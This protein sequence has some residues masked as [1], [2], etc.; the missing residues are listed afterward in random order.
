MAEWVAVTTVCALIAGF[1]AFFGW[2][3]RIDQAL[4]DV[5]M[6]SLKQ[7][8]DPEVVIVAIDEKSLARLGRWPWSRRVHAEL[9]DR[10]REAG[11]GP[12][13]LDILFS[14]RQEEASGDQV[15][16]EAIRRHG[17]V[18]LPWAGNTSIGAAY[19]LGREPLFARDA[20]A[21]GHAHVEFDP[22]GIVRSVYLWE[23]NGEVM[24]PQ[25]GLA[26]LI[27][28][29]PPAAARYV[30]DG[31]RPAGA[32]PASHWLRIPFSGPPGAHRRVSFVD[33]LDR[34]ADPALLKGKV[35]LVGAVAQGMG[36]VVPTPTSAYTRPMPGVEVNA[37]IFSALRGDRTI[38]VASPLGAA[39]LSSLAV[40]VLML[41]MVRLSPRES[42]L[43]AFAITGA[44][45]LAP[46]VALTNWHVWLPPA[47]ALIG[48]MAAYPL[49]SWRRLE[50]TQRYL[51]EELDALMREAG[52]WRPV[53]GEGDS[54]GERSAD[55]VYRRLARLRETASRQRQLRHF[56]LDTLEGL[57]TGVVV[58]GAGSQLQLH[59][60]RAGILLGAEG[61]DE[62]LPVLR[63][64]KWP[65][66]IPLEDGLPV[67]REEPISVEVLGAEGQTL[68]VT[69]AALHDRRSRMHGVVLSM[70]DITQIKQAQARR[71]AAMQYLSHDLRSPLSSIVTM[72]EAFED[73]PQMAHGVPRDAMQRVSLYAS[74]ALELTENLFRL[75][76]AEGVDVRRFVMYDLIQIADDAI[77]EAWAL[78]RA[79]GVHISR[80]ELPDDE[81]PVLCEPSLLK[82]AVLNLLTNAVKYSPEGSEVRL[83]IE[84]EPRGWR[85]EVHDEGDGIGPEDLRLLFQRFGRLEK[86][87]GRRV[88]G[89][90]LGLMIVKTVVERHGGNVEVVS[91]PGLG[92]IFSIRL[93][94]ARQ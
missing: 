61:A 32:S 84:R 42:L 41:S 52:R 11:S 55:P 24:L 57:P 90:G 73:D 13:A 31:S 3:W 40:V 8:V 19:E 6:A 48:C 93:P 15:L 23:S 21:L 86:T 60:R 76:R 14:E 17:Q 18:V 65:A 83:R 74:A 77:E 38:E 72:V 5:S 62:L 47:G 56:M 36:D 2:M 81:Y 82:R 53:A 75:V 89:L 88:A 85:L 63:A 59:N 45:V 80:A 35:V 66:D 54:G 78:S 29:D 27:L 1:I 44:V 50:A 20:A 64:L 9:I 39:I 92:S 37:N 28:V 68:H 70:D 22:D 49:W 91:E 79:R 12:V 25:L 30:L 67:A 94:F 87:T 69:I 7:Q 26:L 58:I 43:V 33:V 10:L 16:A 51:D 4:Y 34:S 71:E 46:A